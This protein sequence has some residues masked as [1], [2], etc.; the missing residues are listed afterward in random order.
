MAQKKRTEYNVGLETGYAAA[1][2][3]YMLRSGEPPINRL[4]VRNAGETDVDDARVEVFSE[5]AFLLPYSVTAR[6][7]KKSTLRFEPGCIISPLYAAA[8]NER[9]SGTITVKVLTADGEL[10]AE[11]T[12]EVALLAFNE[13]DFGLRPENLAAFVTK[14]AAIRSLG[15][16]IDKKLADWKRGKTAFYAGCDRND[17]RYYFAAAYSVL[18]ERSI[19][20]AE[21]DGSMDI[22][23]SGH[24][25]MLKNKTATE[26]ELALLFASLLETAGIHCVLGR[27]AGEWY[28]GAFLTDECFGSAV[29]DDAS[30][31]IN[32]TRRGVNE[33]SLVPVSGITDGVNFESAERR[34]AAD[35]AK[36]APDFF[37]DLTYARISG[38][39]PMPERVKRGAGYD[40]IEPKEY[41]RDAKPEKIKALGGE[42]SGDTVV[43]RE[44]QWER[45]LLDLDMRNPL[46]NFRPTSAAVKLLT[47]DL[48]DLISA[49]CGGEEFAL[50]PTLPGESTLLGALADPFDK[51]TSLKPVR[52]LINYEYKAGKLRV[53][54]SG[55]DFDR[56][57][58]VVYRKEKS[59]QEESGTASL[60]VAAGFLRWQTSGEEE[61]RYAPVLLFPVT[62]VRKGTTSPS[63]SIEVQGDDIH[64][65]TTL[66]EYLYRC[67]DLDLRALSEFRS[68]TPDGYSAAVA[69]VRSEIAGQAGFEVVDGAYLCSL[70]F[71]GYR[72][73]KDVRTE[74]EALRSSKLIRSLIGNKS[75]F[76]ALDAL[77]G[78]RSADEA[79]DEGIL[80]PIGADSSQYSAIVDSLDKS[81]VLHG[82]PGTGKSQTITNIIANNIYRGKR[83]LFVAEKMAALSVVYK[84]LQAIG[85]GD[86]C[87]E[88]YSEKTKKSD[89]ISSVART[90][91]LTKSEEADE[92]SCAELAAI[93][94]KLGGE[95]R[96]M[97][98][99]KP[100]GF[101]IYDAI[102]GYLK[103]EDAPDCF[104]IDSL[105]Y[106]KLTRESFREYVGMLTDLTVSAKEC[107][108][109]GRSP[110]R[111]INAVGYTPKW[112]KN[113]DMTLEIYARELRSLRFYARA[114]VPHFNMRTVS[115]TREKLAGLYALAKYLRC[116]ENI[117]KL[118]ERRENVELFA[119]ADSLVALFDREKRLK[120]AFA[121]R[122]EAFPES[123]FY[124][125]EVIEAGK[126]ESASA[127]L[128]KR[129][130]GSVK[131]ALAKSD[132]GE[133]FSA[134][135]AIA[136]NRLRI[137][138]RKAK[139]AAAFTGSEERVV[140][141]AEETCAFAAAGKAIYAE[142]DERVFF[143]SCRII[144][145][146][147]PFLLLD[148]YAGEYER[149]ENARAD[150]AKVFSAD[151]ECTSAELN[152]EIEYVAGVQKN[153]DKISGWCR[154]REIAEKCRRSGFEFV[155][156]PLSLG[157]VAPED[158]LR[159]FEKRVY[160][161]FIKSEVA[162][163]DRLCRFSG[164]ALDETIERFR[165]A[166]DEYEKYAR[167]ALRAAL[168]ARIPSPLEDG[169]HNLERVVLMR[170]DKTGGKGVTLRKFFTEIPNI[171]KAACP[172]MLMSPSSVAQFLD[173]ALDKFD[174][175]VFDEASQVPTA[176]AVGA[177]ARAERVVVVGDPRQLPPTS[178][179]GSDFRDEEH[180]E[181][182]D[183]ESILDDCLAVGMPERH[184]LWH[185]RSHHESLIAFSNAFFYDN[186]LLTF[187]SPSESDGR[188][189]LCY[190][191][192]VYD[193]GG[194]KCNAAEAEA[195]VSD[196]IRRLRDPIGKTRSIGVVT[197]SSS[198]QA[199]VEDKLAKEIDRLGLQK[200]AYEC[201]EPLFV[202]NLENVQGDER[203]VILFSVG[204]GPDKA[205]KLSLNFGPLNQAGGERRLNVAATRARMEMRVFSSIR[206]GMIDLG[207][208][209][210][211]GVK[212]L[213]AF[214][215]YAERGREMLA[216][217]YA[218]AGEKPTGI[219]RFVAEALSE[220][221]L[222]CDYN[223]GVSD[224]KI[225]AAVVDPRDK[226]K[227]IL[228]I[229]C[230]G[231][232][233]ARIPGVRDRATVRT[234]ILKTLGWNVL[235][236]WTIDYLSNPKRE[237]AK[238]K[239]AVA[240]LTGAGKTNKKAAKETLGRYKKAYKKLAVRTPSKAGADFV[241]TDEGR[242]AVA[243]KAE[244]IVRVESPVT[245]EYLTLRLREIFAVPR[246][247][248]K[249]CAA[250]V[251]A[252]RGLRNLVRSDGGEYRYLTAEPEVFRPLD[253]KTSRDYSDVCPEEIAVAARCA[254][255]LNGQ[256]SREALIRD[257][258]LLMNAKKTAKTCE[259]TARGVDHAAAVGLILVTVDGTY[260]A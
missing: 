133:Y 141:A 29:V 244:A 120:A 193:R 158:V 111:G 236:L 20:K 248:K 67:F 56:A 187:P 228:A 60:Y 17:V 83:V 220:R 37:I 23:I 150:F 39:K 73:W 138:E 99:K 74:T 38:I 13:C 125:A 174:L 191:D 212:S 169:E 71:S 53:P 145:D 143:E 242:E 107:G 185:Y 224:F 148:Y 254:L 252:V 147:Q 5:P 16:L 206:S 226:N 47:A 100:I 137:E 94:D 165:G 204:Y 65:N 63:Y 216:I 12:A 54:L 135:T 209:S 35:V 225:D 146:N 180:P 170:A 78:D 160:A 97:H 6:L 243:A 116:S 88:L 66:L 30:G 51:A 157:E 188:V 48:D 159:C 33:M 27:I 130:S 106:E 59:R 167:A 153:M 22:L 257:V 249:A 144:A 230:D 190:V 91:S 155:L 154:Y 219:G 3:Y 260:T 84:R 96:A 251:E 240:A 195:L 227:Y 2:S 57:L 89:V 208:T 95:M 245:E 253:D 4:Y 1:I 197:F 49:L 80:L 42:I 171:M 85:I 122:F 126:K 217:D 52:D 132:R 26:P 24:E 102:V 183:L 117:E 163:D 8:I 149:A 202:K 128:T 58:T 134:L 121:E 34:A 152:A 28:V 119:V 201:A 46:L 124:A 82:P 182:E 45:R 81:F 177:I 43:S 229:V 113:A 115:L 55:K 15:A 36:L 25:E 186:R 211:K 184:L 75:E 246:T 93:T 189:S 87:L 161:E 172:C 198:Q 79:I 112:R 199:Y 164:L 62:M 40:L 258:L 205:G 127:K 221:G 232:N 108:V 70:S 105:F 239:A 77:G 140:A 166:S 200:E 250:I 142:F 139:L 259:L 98:E 175:V 19:V 218:A 222:K 203:D 192:G 179:F 178:F 255:E 247:S 92:T 69:R 213:K 7:P 72:M 90:T 11:D 76:T 61:F 68:E 181:I 156:E 129:Y 234:R 173:P 41:D 233:E 64:V 210:A 237:I 196:V 104:T 256:R 114:L 207:R 110:F 235:N 151:E 194:S 86:F 162:L 101:S 118:L 50:S 44:K 32:R 223:V 238:I 103:N 18:G 14:S 168:T 31:I 241:T 136:E 9:T 131:Y 231:E 109:L 214:L 10:L 176:K 21:T 123:A 215:E